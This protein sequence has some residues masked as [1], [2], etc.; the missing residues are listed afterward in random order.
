MGLKIAV[1]INLLTCEYENSL[2][3]IE[4]K[5]S[6]TVIRKYCGII[7]NMC[8]EFSLVNTKSIKLIFSE[9]SMT[10]V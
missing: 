8:I 9:L 5:I 6:P 2:Q 10:K 4:N 3:V 7:H 1:L